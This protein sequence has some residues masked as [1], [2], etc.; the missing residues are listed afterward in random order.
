[1][2]G[3]LEGAPFITAS[4]NL[5][6]GQSLLLYTDGVT[7]AADASLAMYDEQRLLDCLRALPAAASAESTIVAINR[8]VEA[9]VAGAEPSDDI[10]MLALTWRGPQAQTPPAQAAQA[11]PADADTEGIAQHS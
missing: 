4:L 2:L 3:I 7:E 5:A 9:F 10:T 8:D 6:P 1:M 11:R